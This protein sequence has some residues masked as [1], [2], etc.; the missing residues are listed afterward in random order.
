ML[1]V[2]RLAPVIEG[3]LKVIPLGRNARDPLEVHQ[4]LT[5]LTLGG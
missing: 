4:L 3:W 1:T 2:R 5:R